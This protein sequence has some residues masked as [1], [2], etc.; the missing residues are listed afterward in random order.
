M[1]EMGEK[2]QDLTVFRTELKYMIDLPDRLHLIK[3]LNTLLVLDTYGG[4][5]GYYVRSVYFDSFDNQ[6]YNEKMKKF[7]FL[8]R[9]RLR[10]YDIHSPI[11]KF[12]IK[13]KKA[14]RQIKDSLIVTREDAKELIK[15]NFEVF[16]HYEGETAELGYEIC[17]TMGYRPV[18]M[19][20]YKRRAYT[21]PFFNTRITLDNELQYCNFDYD[22]FKEKPNYKKVMPQQYTILEVKYARFLFPQLQDVLKECNLQKCPVSKFASS[23]ELM[24]HYYY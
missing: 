15:G 2:T 19:V 1:E 5:D 14:G 4:Y 8:K 17:T 20:Q 18:S 22:L 21:H 11:A 6:D 10:I 9:V 13:R 23:R 12:E 7:T 3:R 24:Q 16:K